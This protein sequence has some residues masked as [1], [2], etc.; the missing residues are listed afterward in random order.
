MTVN[1]LEG[2]KEYTILLILTDGEIHDMK[3]TIDTLLDMYALPISIIIVG[4]GDADFSKM[5]VLD[6]DE[7]LYGS[8]G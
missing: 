3:S 2:S 4:I 6:G 8:S 1:K 5:V 7:G